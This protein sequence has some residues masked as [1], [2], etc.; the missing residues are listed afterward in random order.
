M[1][2]KV[3][4]IEKNGK[5]VDMM[6]IMDD[7]SIY[8]NGMTLKEQIDNIRRAIRVGELFLGAFENADKLLEKYPNGS[9]LVAGTYAL[10][11]DIDAFYI[12]DVETLTW[13]AVIGAASGILQLNGLT[14][15]HGV[16][17][18][19]GGDIDAAVPSSNVVDQTISQHLEYL[20]SSTKELKEAAYY[21]P[22]LTGTLVKESGA[23]VLQL[24]AATEMKG[25]LSG[26]VVTFTLTQETDGRNNSLPVKY[27]IS[28]DDGTDEEGIITGKSVRST[29]D[30]LTRGQFK[31]AASTYY[32]VV[33]YNRAV[34]SFMDL[35]KDE[36]VVRKYQF[37]NWYSNASGGYYTTINIA[38]SDFNVLGITKVD[39]NKK[40]SVVVDY[41]YTTGGTSTT[42]T[43]TSDEQFSG[44]VTIAV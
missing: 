43:I 24:Y 34:C 21:V 19:T 23:Y 14:A 36:Y 33:F 9:D 28:Y 7:L 44:E 37:R 32:N 1:E 5:L 22:L 30:Q 13:K 38:Y 42:L 41:E 27:R 15:T 16:L 31:V 40:T 18:I 12:Y 4:Q 35:S 25:N 20:A 11:T 8:T 6:P 26:A 10:V 3:L 2:R 29:S 17:T 39:G